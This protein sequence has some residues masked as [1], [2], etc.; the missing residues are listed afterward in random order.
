MKQYSRWVFSVVF[1]FSGP[2]A[3]GQ[4]GGFT[5][6]VERGNTDIVEGMTA[7]EGGDYRTGVRLLRSGLDRSAGNLQGRVVLAEVLEVVVLR[8]DRAAEVLVGGLEHGGIHEYGYLRTTLRFLLKHERHDFIRS[9]T[10]SYLYAEG[11]DSRAKGALAYALAHSYYLTGDF[12]ASLQYLQ[13][14]GVQQSL[15]GK[16]LRARIHWD[17]GDRAEA[18]ALLNAGLKIAGREEASDIF[19][20]IVDYQTSQ[21]DWRAAVLTAKLWRL[22]TPGG[23]QP[24][25]QLFRLLHMQGDTEAAVHEARS[26]IDQFS[27]NEDALESLADQT[28]DLGKVELAR[29]LHSIAEAEGFRTE[30]FALLLVEAHVAAGAYSEAMASAQRIL[31]EQPGRPPGYRAM[32]HALR[33]VARC[34]EEGSGGMD[35]ELEALVLNASFGPAAFSAIARRMEEVDCFHEAMMVLEAGLK[36]FPESGGLGASLSRLSAER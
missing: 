13:N 27:K 15:E 5:A 31:A 34:G 1:L 3:F 25:I 4:E 20:L 19:K 8:S 16:V 22:R 32:L 11:I 10:P 35:E 29:E 9:I 28:A 12:E 17:Q 23:Y 33:A 7:V 14:F 30:T 21:G 18:F 24:R 26:L 36:R 6:L 2:A